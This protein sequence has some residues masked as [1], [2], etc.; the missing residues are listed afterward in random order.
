[1][2]MPP[3]QPP[4]R[5]ARSADPAAL[6]SVENPANIPADVP[7]LAGRQRDTDRIFFVAPPDEIGP[8]RAAESSLKVGK[9]PLPIGMRALIW[10][11]AP[12]PALA[13]FFVVYS[14]V[15]DPDDRL[16]YAGLAGGTVLLLGV[17]LAFYFTRFKVACAYVGQLGAVRYTLSG[18]FTNP[19]RVE[20]LRFSQAAE[21]RTS[22]TRHFVNGV[23]TGTHYKFKWTD[24]KGAL[25]LSLAGQHKG[26]DGLPKAGDP[27]HFAAAAERSWSNFLL[28]NRADQELA[29]NGCLASPS[30]PKKPSSLARVSLS[31]TSPAAPTAAMPPTSNP[32]ASTRA[33]SPSSTATPSGTP[34]RASFPFPMA[35]WATPISS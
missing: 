12:L 7:D 11:L 4:P 1:M 3:V 30:I 28:L 34:P 29:E 8:L 15:R 25:V 24:P 10:A 2:S 22:Q 20:S 17:G 16:F 35:T 26:K 19:P 21:L 9:R 27:F 5:F 32:S 23:Y 14:T 33:R 13:V 6:V 31:F 18:S